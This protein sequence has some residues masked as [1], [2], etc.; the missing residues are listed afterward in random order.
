MNREIFPDLRLDRWRDSRDTLWGYARALAAI[1]REASP[2]HPFWWHTTLYVSRQGLTTSEI[3]HQS[4][5]FEIELDLIDQRAV[6]RSRELGVSSW[7]LVGQTPGQFFEQTI[8]V[9]ASLGVETGVE[10]PEA[11]GDCHGSWDVAAIQ[12]F[13]RALTRVDAIFERFRS[14]LDGKTSPVHLF[15]HHFDLSLLWL[16]GRSVEGEEASEPELAS[17]QLTFGFSTGDDNLSEPYF[18]ATAYPEPE[19]FVGSPLPEP[20]FWNSDGFS[21]AVLRYSDVRQ[22]DEPESLVARFLN[23][24]HRAGADL[25]KS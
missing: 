5:S 4:S 15:G 21:G 3:P 6:L 2:H 7:P 13:G 8:Q 10:M 19:E 16:S 25:M 1:R 11:P 18:Y 9:L 12:R 14:D 23:D 22:S 20:A 24:T 17:E